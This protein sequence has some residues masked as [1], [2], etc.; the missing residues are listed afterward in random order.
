MPV[1]IDEVDD[2]KVSALFVL[3]DTN[4]DGAHPS[5]LPTVLKYPALKP[6]VNAP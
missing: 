4:D 1:D 2:V 6:P 5:L 3:D